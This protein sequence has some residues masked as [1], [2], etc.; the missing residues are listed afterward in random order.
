MERAVAHR[1]R[2]RERKLVAALAVSNGRLGLAHHTPEYQEQRAR[3]LAAAGVT[4]LNVARAMDFDYP[5]DGWTYRRVQS[6][7]GPARLNGERRRVAA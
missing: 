5:D 1:E 6:M 7:L 4:H 2:E 3:A